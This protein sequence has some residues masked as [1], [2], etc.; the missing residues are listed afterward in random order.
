M[1]F[2][3][4]L[5]VYAAAA[6]ITLVAWVLNVAQLYWMAGVL[7]FLPTGSRLFA[8]LERW[9]LELERE[10]PQAA[11]QGETVTIRLLARN[12]VALP[13]L[14]LSV[15]DIL[16]EG[17]EAVDAEPLPLHLPPGGRDTAEY[18][19]RLRRRGSHTIPGTWVHSTDLLGLCDQ[20]ARFPLTS[21]VLVYPR[22][23]ELPARVLARELGGGS[24][25][26][27]TTSR[28]GEG[29]SF[30]GIREYRPGD[31]LRHVHWRSTARRGSLAVVEWEAEE[32]HSALLAIETLKG[33]EKRLTGGTTLD[34][35]AGLAASLAA[36]MLRAGN[37][38]RLLAPGTSEWRAA[39][40]RGP[41]A[42]P[43]LLETLARVQATSDISLA[44]EIRRVTPQL[45][46]GSVVCWLTAQPDE[47]LVTTMRY[48][49]NVRLRPVLYAFIDTAPG[50]SSDWE[51]TAREVEGMG[52][53]VVRLHGGDELVRLLLD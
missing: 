46:P 7:V 2:T 51:K 9:G 4:L 18:A 15:R 17:L 16:P 45:E 50:P 47:H 48:L 34:A 36:E 14:H 42:L 21:E 20:K 39:A 32:S 35:A 29:S 31:P 38:V 37:A 28:K 26:L 49:Q 27:E 8:L 44:A 19:V 22:V 33:S 1:T 41:E 52:I 6:A 24:A 13:K 12:T 53:P 5:T 23:V 11:H 10:A 40:E 25:P 30:F 43:F 3:K